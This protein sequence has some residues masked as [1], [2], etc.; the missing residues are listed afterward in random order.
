MPEKR[1]FVRLN[2][3]I[4]AKWKKIT[5][6]PDTKLNNL[7]IIRNISRGGICLNMHKKL[8]IGDK[9]LL[10]IKLPTKKIIKAK[11][12]VVWIKDM[13]ILDLEREEEYEVGVE[14]SEMCN[15]DRQEINKFLFESLAY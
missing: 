8:K 9:L 10:E 2:I 3:K 4:L 5:G 13:G 7:D 6:T 14:F 15:E 1:K 12:K 11:G